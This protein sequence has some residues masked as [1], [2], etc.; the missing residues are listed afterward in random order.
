MQ[1]LNTTTI[2]QS[3]LDWD[4]QGHQTTDE[5]LKWSGLMTTLL[6]LCAN[7][8]GFITLR[9]LFSGVCRFPQ[10]EFLSSGWSTLK[11]RLQPSVARF[12]INFQWAAGRKKFEACFCARSEMI[13]IKSWFHCNFCVISKMFLRIKKTQIGL[14]WYRDCATVD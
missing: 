10:V 11:I 5:S 13:M 4:S 7:L 9:G 12:L 8:P 1:P 6:S 2:K 3:R 14:G